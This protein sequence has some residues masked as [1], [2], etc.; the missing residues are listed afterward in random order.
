MSRPLSTLLVALQCLYMS[1]PQLVH[2][3]ISLTQIGL[4]LAILDEEVLD[5]SDEVGA[6]VP[7]LL[8]LPPVHRSR[9]GQGFPGGF[10]LADDLPAVALRH[11]RLLTAAALRVRRLDP[12]ER[13]RLSV[14]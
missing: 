7:V 11:V 6:D 5:L 1:G 13:R 9:Q 12:P 3:L 4:V 14:G 2:I 8:F 10:A